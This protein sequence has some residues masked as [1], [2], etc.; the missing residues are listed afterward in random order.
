MDASNGR[1]H[2][3]NQGIFLNWISNADIR[4]GGGQVVVDGS[5]QSIT[6]LQ[7]VDAR[8]TVLSSS[9]TRSADAAMSATPNS[10]RETNFHSPIQQ[11]NPATP[12]TVDYSRVGPDLHLNR[13]TNNSINGLQVRVQTAVPNQLEKLTVQG[14]FDDIDVVHFLPENLEIQGTPGGAIL[15][16]DPPSTTNVRL[17][18]QTGGTLP[19]GLYTYR[20]TTINAQGVESLGSEATTSVF[21]SGTTRTVVVSNIPSNASRIYRSGPN[22][23]GPY[24]LIGELSSA[25]GA[26]IDTGT[27]LG[28]T[29]SEN[30]A[31]VRTRLDARLVIDAGTVVKS[32]ARIDVS[33][34]AQLIA[35]GTAGNPVVFTSLNDIRYGAG[36][37]F[38]TANRG[39][40]QTAVAG[41]WGGIYVGHTS[42]ASLDHVVVAF[43]GGTT[44]VQGGF[45][46][47]GA[48]EAHQADLRVAHSRLEFN[49]SG[50]GT[51]TAADRGGR[52][53]NAEGTIFVRGAQPILVDNIIANNVGPAISIDVSSLNSSSVEDYGR[54]TGRLGPV[55]DKV[56]N[57]GPLVSKNRI[58]NNGINGMVVRGGNLT[59]EGV[60]DDTGIV[61]VVQD[62]IVVPDFQHYGGLRLLSASDQSL[63]IKLDGAQAGFTATGQPLDNADRIGGSIQVV[64][65]PHHPV[66]L[67]SLHDDS[68]GAGFTIAGSQQVDTNNNGDATS[69]TAGN[70]SGILLETYSNDRNV[71]L[72]QERESPLLGAPASNNTPGQSQFLGSLAPNEK[73]GNENLR[74]GF[75]LSGVLSAP[76][77]LDVY[78]F[79]ADA[80]TE[81]WLDI[82]RTNNSLDTVIELVDAN[83]RTLALSDSSLLEERDP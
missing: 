82:D 55:A 50:A 75:Q 43:G 36:G 19:I 74:L 56:G 10:F 4:Y 58:D 16:Q 40:G 66:I 71:V 23:Q 14:R 81:V 72:T 64:G 2:L 63:V 60:W 48:I 17:A 15:A 24:T 67:T 52:G 29:L 26:F 11:G 54:S 18:V 13:I 53:S 61:H 33:M 35:E 69:P 41:D 22:G 42:S 49:D 65:T 83:G 80:G 34:G 44:R 3:E 59:T 37:T 5:S 25:V 62:Q 31:S 6:P 79:R 57:Q 73:A 27:S 12:F 32:R 30:F 1:N 21:A 45:S 76:S 78:S 8:P 77:D 7:M 28:Q 38:D 47:F 39:G 68:V 9:I 70:W 46:D 20:F 51:S